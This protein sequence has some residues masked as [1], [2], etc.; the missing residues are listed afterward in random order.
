[1]THGSLRRTI[2]TQ[3]QSTHSKP[4]LAIWSDH[5]QPAIVFADATASDG[6]VGPHRDH[7]VVAL[8]RGEAGSFSAVAGQRSVTQPAIKM[9][10]L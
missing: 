2:L 7:R 6:Q 8:A 3:L 4:R 10:G 5:T 1:V 9:G